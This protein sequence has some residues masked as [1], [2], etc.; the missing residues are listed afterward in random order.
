[1]SSNSNDQI[2]LRQYLLGQLTDPAREE[3]EQRL[4]SDDD[5]FEELLAAEDELIDESLAGELSGD[6]RESFARFFLITPEREQR[7]WFRRALKRHLRKPPPPPLPAPAPR[8]SWFE[9][10]AFRTAAAVA[11][12]VIIVGIVSIIRPRRPPTVALVTLTI[13]TSDR[14]E[15]AQATELKLPLNVDQLRLRLTLPEPL[16][17]AKGYRVELLNGN[18]D[19]KSLD[20]AAQVEQAVEV[21]VPASEF[22]RGQ[23]AL[24]VYA[25]KPDGTEQRIRGSYF[26]TVR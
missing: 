13:S 23:Y 11:A 2:N 24:N 4:F 5:L 16:I 19:T 21:V 7:L 25:I 12:L 15:G 9:G 8:P 20:R 14:A 17:P 18:G 26:L 1:M 6:D 10:W 3:F 22:S